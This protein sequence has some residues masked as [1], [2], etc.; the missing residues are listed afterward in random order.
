M[1]VLNLLPMLVTAVLAADQGKKCDIL[2]AKGCSGDN[3]VQCYTWP[4]R[5]FM[6]WNYVESCFDQ[7]KKCS[8]AGTCYCP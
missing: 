4:G 5:T 7:G 3:A 2:N 1:L 8:G 6:T